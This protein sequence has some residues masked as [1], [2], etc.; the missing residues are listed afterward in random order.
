[1]RRSI[2]LVA[3]FVL[4]AAIPAAVTASKPFRET[5]HVASLYCDGIAPTSGTG[6]LYLGVFVSELYGPDAF[7]D[8][9]TSAEPSG[10]PDFTRDYEQPVD[11]AGTLD[12]FTISFPVVDSDGDPAG[13]ALITG[14]STPVGEVQTFD[15]NFSFGNVKVQ[16]AYVIQPLAA[17][18]TIDVADRTF[19]LADCFADDTVVTTFQTNPNSFVESF[20]FADTRCEIENEDGTVGGVFID[21]TSDEVFVDASLF[22]GPGTPLA[23]NGFVMLT[24][25]S[26]SGSLD[27]Y[28][29]ETGEPVGGT[30]SID[31]S[32]TAGN[33]YSYVLTDGAGKQMVRGQLI[34]VEGTLTFP[35]MPSFDLGE[36]VAFAGEAKDI[37]HQPQGPQ[38]KGKAPA[39]D[40][41]A[42]ALR[43]AVGAKTSQSTRAAALD[44]EAAYPCME[45]DDPFIG[46]HVVIPVEHTVWFKV[47]GT[48][49][50]VTVDTAGSDFDSVAAAYVSDGAG[51]FTNVACVD[52]VP[53]DPIGRT[54]QAAVTFPTVAGTT[55]YVQIGGF[56]GF[57]SY[58]NLRVAVR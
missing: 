2:A 25:G 34:D 57:Q 28:D 3:A 38:P 37:F 55:Y 24:D 16:S 8:L 40:L 49:A 27:V 9:W 51:G 23:A 13:V 5:D 58:G 30:A 19:S 43:L 39:N 35:E 32:L 26:G 44:Q 17:V 10:P 22:E 33:S 31:L 36:C 12:D 20:T 46:E 4:I 15:D 47:P 18:G 42:G 45:F 7:L 53:L 54:L 6:F 50:A 56:P 11:V 48:G 41:P 29:P 21:A 14:S 52:D 1:M